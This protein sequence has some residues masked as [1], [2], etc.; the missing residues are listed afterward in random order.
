MPVITCAACVQVAAVELPVLHVLVL[1]EV[2]LRL[3]QPDAPEAESPP[4]AVRRVVAIAAELHRV[5]HV[6]MARNRDRGADG[7]TAVV[8]GVVK[9]PVWL[10][11]YPFTGMPVLLA[12]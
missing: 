3:A 12:G 4:L 11:G 9:A 2:V 10:N 1:S 8:T 6:V 7:R 5:D